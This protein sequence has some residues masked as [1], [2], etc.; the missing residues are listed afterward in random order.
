MGKAD[1]NVTF[2]QGPTMR[3]KVITFNIVDIPY[4]YNAIFGR[5]TII[6]FAAVIHQP[7]LCMK[8][9]TA[10]GVVTV[11][12]SQEEARRCEDNTSQSSKNVHAIK[13]Q[14]KTEDEGCQQE[15]ETQEATEGLQPAEHTK[16]VPLCEDVP[17][18]TITIGKGLQQAEEERL[19][20]FLRNNQNVFAWSSADLKA[21]SRDVMEH[22]LKVDPKHK[23]V[24]QRLRTMSEERKKAA[25]AEV[26]KLLD[27]GVIREVQ[28][29]EWLAS[30]VMVKKKNGKWQ[31]CIDFMNVNKACPKDDY[32]LPRIDTLVDVATGSKMMSMLDCFHGYHQIWTRKCDEEKPVSQHPSAPFAI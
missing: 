32:P 20:C 25:Q 6:K 10:G 13:D 21:V 14:K 9:P 4:P 1:I 16:R 28:F 30:V 5:N 2:S 31:M 17:D 24:R 26:Q 18:R 19:V 22:V 27:T 12:G 23:P 7:Y 11:F 3:M 8:I 15:T 29:S